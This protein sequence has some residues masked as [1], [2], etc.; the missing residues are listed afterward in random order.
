MNVCF[1]DISG[2]QAFNYSQLQEYQTSWEMFRRVEMYNSNVSTQ[3]FFG[4]TTLKYWQFP[5][6]EANILYRQGLSLHTYYI[7]FSTVVQK[8]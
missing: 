5:N 3:R 1:S 7:G 6:Q 2:I 8:N 4:N